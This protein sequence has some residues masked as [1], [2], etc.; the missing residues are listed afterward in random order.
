MN[1]FNKFSKKQANT[2][3]NVATKNSPNP[4][5]Y[6]IG[7]LQSRA[8]A[9]VLLRN[10]KRTEIAIQIVYVSPDGTRKNGLILRYPVPVGKDL[11]EDQRAV[12]IIRERME[13]RPDER[14]HDPSQTRVEYVRL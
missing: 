14:K 13:R 12:A 10:K 7:S 4:G 6:P 8:A 3:S 1:S 9:R 5:D 2:L 11:E